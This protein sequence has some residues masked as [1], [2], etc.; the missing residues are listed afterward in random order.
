MAHGADERIFANRSARRLTRRDM[1]KLAGVSGLGMAL[2]TACGQQAPAAKP[3]DAPKPAESKP[4]APAATTAPAAP[5]AQQAPAQKPA[6]AAKPAEAPKPVAGSGQTPK[7]GGT[8]RAHIYTEDPP[9]L[10]PYLNV[11]FRVQEFAAF[12]YSRLLMSKKGPGIPNSAY[13]MEGDLAESWKPSADGKTWTFNLRPDAKWHNVAPMNGRPVT[14]ADVAWSFERFMKVSPQKTTFEIVDSVGAPSDKVVEFKLK[15]VYAPFE[16]A[17]GAPIFWIMPKELIEAEGDASKRVVGSG[18]FVFDKHDKGISFSGKKNKDYY[19]KGEPHVDEVVALIIPDTATQMA[20]LRGKELDFVQVAQQDLESLKKTNPEIQIVEWEYLNIPFIYWHVDQPPYNDPR[21]RQAFSMAVD[22][23]EM[24]SVVY[25]GRGNWNNAVP[26]ALS[27]WWLDPR[28]P[29]QGE[30]AKFFKHDPAEAKKLLAAAGFPDGLKV[31][32]IATPGYSQTFNQQVEL[33]AA[34]LKKS[35][36][37]ATIKQQEYAAYIGTTFR[38]Q[39]PSENN[40]M[41]FGL[42]TP[43]TEPHDFLFNMYHP[44]GTRNH[45]GVNDPK[46]TEMIEKQA[47]TLDKAERKKQIFE[48]QRYLGEM[49]YYPPN[50][51]SYRTAGIA[52]NIRD[53]YPR[54]DYGLGAEVIPKLWI[55]K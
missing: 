1:L 25:N 38:G 24:V 17:I 12:F 41:V 4:A 36:I 42:E 19:R 44:K 27:E 26:W 21:V 48:I 35:G 54:S 6:E 15:D 11:S 8:F 40:T 53:F 10:D 30:T 46:L 52:A 47:K 39:F 18:P 5:A 14:A 29:E 49:M 13:I 31:D 2:L 55:D 9:T 45:A 22:R 33:V 32:L 50:A 51:A 20:G 3:A 23:D 16:A 7:D 37:E 34:Q 43:F 28:S